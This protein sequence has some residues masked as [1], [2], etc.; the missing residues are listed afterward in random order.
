MT[1]ISLPPSSLTLTRVLHLTWNP[2]P[3]DLTPE[4]RKLAVEELQDFAAGIKTE[5]TIGA[6]S[7]GLWNPIP[8]WLNA[9]EDLT[10]TQ[11]ERLADALSAYASDISK[12]AMVGLP[13]VTFEVG[14]D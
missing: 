10:E 3:G 1:P 6:L 11:V 5:M 12:G 9:W 7:V 2:L 13:C 8:T 14:D 4:E